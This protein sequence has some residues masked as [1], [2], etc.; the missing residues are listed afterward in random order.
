MLTPQ[1]KRNAMF[2]LFMIDLTYLIKVGKSGTESWLFMD[3][4]PILP[5]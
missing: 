3:N 1:A 4:K 2:F 5:K